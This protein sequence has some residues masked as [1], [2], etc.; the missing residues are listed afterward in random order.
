MVPAEQVGQVLQAVQVGGQDPLQF[1]QVLRPAHS[2][3]HE[4]VWAAT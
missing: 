4:T 2:P 3:E 1:G